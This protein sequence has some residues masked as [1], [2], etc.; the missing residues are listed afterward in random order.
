MGRGPLRIAATAVL[1]LSGCVALAACGDG[2]AVQGNREVAGG[3]AARG[4]AILTANTHG[5]GGCHTIPGIPN[6]HGTVGPPLHG[7]ALRGYVAGRLPNDPG[8]L[9]RWISGPQE[10]DPR[11]AM[12]DTGITTAEAAHVAAYLYTLRDI[13]K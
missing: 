9:V 2:N 5:C 3:E 13:P 4:K 6:A 12:P 7:M 1:G 11:S 8:N 10:I